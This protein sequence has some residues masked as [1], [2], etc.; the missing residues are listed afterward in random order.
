[1]TIGIY[2]LRFIG[3]DKV[4]VGQSINIE[5]RFKS[6]CTDMRIGKAVKK[7]KEA[8]ETYGLP[9]YEVIFICEKEEL[10]DIE[11]EAI[12]IY[13]AIS[14]GFNTMSKYG[15]S[16]EL[17]GD[18]C[19]NS[20]YTNEQVL[21]VFGYLVEC[22][23]MTH[24][25]ITEITGVTRGVIADISMCATHIWIEKLMPEKYAILRELHLNRRKMRRTAES[26]GISYP[27]IKDPEGNTYY[28]ESIRGFARDHGLNPNALGRVLRKQAI[29]HEGWILN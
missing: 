9:T 16:S 10:N 18:A 7:L 28:I 12:D 6:H 1:M 26:R 21:E 2:I 8:Y 23:H 15:F 22:P 29:S 3:T 14:N 25:D 4:Y 5:S 20:K 24:K 19:G 17:Y 11:K 27:S 13:D